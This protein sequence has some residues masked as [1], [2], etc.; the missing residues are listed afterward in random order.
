MPLPYK[1]PVGGHR[2]THQLYTPLQERTYPPFGARSHKSSVPQSTPQKTK[3][4]NVWKSCTRGN[5]I[6]TA[7]IPRDAH[8]E[9][10]PKGKRGGTW[11]NGKGG[12]SKKIRIQSSEIPGCEYVSR[13]SPAN[14]KGPRRKRSATEEERQSYHNYRLTGMEAL[15]ATQ[16]HCQHLA[17]KSRK[18]RKHGSTQQRSQEVTVKY[19]T[20]KGKGKLVEVV[21]EDIALLGIVMHRGAAEANDRVTHRMI[22]EICRCKREGRETNPKFKILEQ[23]M[24]VVKALKTELTEVGVHYTGEIKNFNLAD[25]M[26]PGS[27]YKGVASMEAGIYLVFSCPSKGNPAMAYVGQSM[28]AHRRFESRNLAYAGLRDMEGEVAR[29]F[30][31]ATPEVNF[32]LHEWRV[33]GQAFYTIPLIELHVSKKDLKGGRSLKQIL[34]SKDPVLTPGERAA[35]REFAGKWERYFITQ[36]GTAGQPF[37]E[38]T[39][40]TSLKPTNARGGNVAGHRERGTKADVRPRRKSQVVAMKKATPADSTHPGVQITLQVFKNKD[41]GFKVKQG[42]KGWQWTTRASWHGTKKGGPSAFKVLQELS[43]VQ[44]SQ[45]R[46]ALRRVGDQEWRHP[47]QQNPQSPTLTLTICPPSMNARAGVTACIACILEGKKWLSHIPACMKDQTNMPFIVPYVNTKLNHM[48]SPTFT[49]IFKQV[50]EKQGATGDEQTIEPPLKYRSVTQLCR[51]LDNQGAMLGRLDGPPKGPPGCP[52]EKFKASFKVQHKAIPGELHLATSDMKAISVLTQDR[53]GTAELQRKMEEGRG[54]RLTTPPQSQQ[55]LRDMIQEA[56]GKYRARQLYARDVTEDCWGLA[57]GDAFDKAVADAVM[58]HLDNAAQP[59]R[60]PP[61]SKAAATRARQLLKHILVT[62][63]EKDTCYGLLCPKL[64]HVVIMQQELN[65]PS[66]RRVG[67]K[68]SAEAKALMDKIQEETDKLNVVKA[69]G[70]QKSAAIN[71]RKINQAVMEGKEAPIVVGDP[72]DR[73]ATMYGSLKQKLIYPEGTPLHGPPPPRGIRE[74]KV[75]TALRPIM[76]ACDTK[77][78]PLCDYMLAMD[79]LFVVELKEIT[80]ELFTLLPPAVAAKYSPEERQQLSAMAFPLPVFEGADGFAEF[81]ERFNRRKLQGIPV[82]QRPRLNL[83]TWDV[84]NCYPSTD[85]QQAIDRRKELTKVIK[86]RRLARHGKGA[87]NPP[88]F[89]DVGLGRSGGIHEFHGRKTD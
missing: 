43:K 63:T 27:S 33:R 55:H 64:A 31:S 28:F 24:R 10:R 57:G 7:A 5:E 14:N 11:R 23:A 72:L 71:R 52:C 70:K 88:I 21:G 77:A 32:A 9:Q 78:T 18:N 50:C 53:A 62:S 25:P 46:E 67:T 84:V 58:G 44:L 36:L 51:T 26:A 69:Y 13:A 16:R 81:V 89:I 30:G 3:D 79:K 40:R 80:F 65:T 66:Y 15:E 22:A 56:S 48:S 74:G 35:F 2:L 38:R 19:H 68:G 42:A 41:A 60:V 82:E 75:T 20:N 59:E 6:A 76:A 73:L 87:G 29:E 85:T 54:L 8:E 12:P 83:D 39:G 17:K 86:K 4:R 45:V 61:L 34:R 37:E 1:P 47:I 49:S